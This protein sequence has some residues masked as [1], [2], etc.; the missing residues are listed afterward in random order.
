MCPQLHEQSLAIIAWQ[1]ITLVHCI[2]AIMAN[3]QDKKGLIP[4]CRRLYDAV[5]N[6]VCQTQISGLTED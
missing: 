2:L 5:D 6:T 3:D 4:E 1:V